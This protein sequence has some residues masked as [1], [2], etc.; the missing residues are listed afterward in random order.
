METVPGRLHCFRRVIREQSLLSRP[1]YAPTLNSGEAR[2][3]EFVAR[4]AAGRALA[5]RRRRLSN[6]PPPSAFQRLPRGAP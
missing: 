3:A 2:R 6:K 5:V 4:F 1:R